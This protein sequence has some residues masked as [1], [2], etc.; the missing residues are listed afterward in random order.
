ML[1]AAGQQ[2]V[3]HSFTGGAGGGTP[4]AGVIRDAAGNLYGTTSLGGTAG[5]GVVYRLG[6]AGHETVLYNFT[7][8]A[9]GATPPSGVI[10]DAAGNLYGTTYSGGSANFGVVYK[11]DPAGNETVLYSFTGGVDG[12]PARRRVDPRS[13][14]KNIYGTTERGGSACCG[15]GGGPA[16]A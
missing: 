14:R 1:D 3:L 10:R 12:G 13:G 6:L 11:L 5:L 4:L 15:N 8:G 16:G 9:D 7:G 2:T